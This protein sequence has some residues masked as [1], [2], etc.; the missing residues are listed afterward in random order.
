[1]VEF[2]AETGDVP[3]PRDH[4]E[5]IK[6]IYLAMAIASVNVF[7]ARVINQGKSALIDMERKDFAEVLTRMAFNY[8]AGE[9]IRRRITSV[10]ETTR[11]TIISA[12]ARGF[13]DGLGQRA[14]ADYVTGL[15]PSFSTARAALIARTETHGAANFGATE[16]AKE[17]GL[18]LRREWISA[19]DAR[20]RDSHNMD[21][22]KIVGMDEAF[23]VGNAR[24]MYPGDP[25]GPADETIN[26]RCVVGFIVDN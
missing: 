3:V 14:V 15:I 8:I 23:D 4:A 21:L 16:A 5:N 25:A 24:L 12:V 11:G 6:A 1:M 22:I 18:K 9:A 10:S 13:A 20:T 19:E 2:F 26:C 7:G 17:T